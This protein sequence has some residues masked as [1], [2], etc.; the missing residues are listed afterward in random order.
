[1]KLEHPHRLPEV[2]HKREIAPDRSERAGPAGDPM[3]QHRGRLDAIAA[4][5]RRL[6]LPRRD[7]THQRVV[8]EKREIARRERRPDRTRHPAIALGV[9]LR[10]E[11]RTVLHDVGRFR[12]IDVRD[13]ARNFYEN[14][15]SRFQQDLR[16]LREKGLV[17]TYWV[18]ARRDGRRN[19]SERIEVV[20]LTRQGQKLIERAGELLPR[21][22]I[23]A[24]LVKPREA[25]H[26]TQIYRA[27]LKEAEKIERAGGRNLRVELDFELKAKIHRDLYAERKA[28]PERDVDDLRQQVADQRRLPV[29]DG[30]IQ[31][32]DARIHYELEEGGRAAFSDIE[33]VTAAYHPAHLRSKVQAGFRMYVS[34]SDRSR[35]AKVED[36]H[37]LLDWVMDL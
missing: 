10:P 34:V 28:A 20:A 11:E 12:V 14:D 17:A 33:V 36:E 32:P 18:N 9:H 26:D 30:Q 21:Q 25:E 7:H 19:N 2:P 37:H 8:E 27:Y 1:M 31:V 23:Y 6:E 24:D 5:P 35:L 29:V 13:L 16:Y 22:K 4:D 15:A 3:P